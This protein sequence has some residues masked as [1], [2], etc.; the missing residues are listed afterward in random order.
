MLGRWANQATA[1]NDFAQACVFHAHLLF[2]YQYTLPS[3]MTKDICATLLSSQ[4]FLCARFQFNAKPSSLL[5][6]HT[7]GV[8]LT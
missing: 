4:I 6:A 1:G 7:L 5:D 2:M 3:E 8:S